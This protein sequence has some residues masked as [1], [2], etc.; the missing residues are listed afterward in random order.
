MTDGNPTNAVSATVTS[1]LNVQP[2][3]TVVASGD[4]TFQAGPGKSILLDP[5][6]G[7]FDGTSLTG[8]T[9]TI[10]GE[11]Q[12]GEVLSANTAGTNI[13]AIYNNGVLTLSG[14]DTPARLPIG[15]QSRDHEWHPLHNSVPVTIDWQISDKPSPARWPPARSKSRPVLRRRRPAVRLKARSRRISTTAIS[16]ISPE[17]LPT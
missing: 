15:A 1:T 2:V 9:V 13:T 16:G 10:A 4:V 5:T 12:P 14:K 17:C 11:F 3:P 8:A 7:A 6:I